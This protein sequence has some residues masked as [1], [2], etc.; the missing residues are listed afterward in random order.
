MRIIENIIPG[1][2]QD[3]IENVS[4]Q[5][6]EWGYLHDASGRG[7]QTNIPAFVHMFLENGQIKSPWYS[8]FESIFCMLSE[9]SGH[10]INLLHR[11]RFGLYLP[12]AGVPEH[13]NI[14]TDSAEP[15]TVLLYYVNDSDG[16]TYFFNHQNE[17]VDTV[18]AKKGR[19]V[20]FDGSIK[21]ASSCPKNGS[22]ITLNI[23][24]KKGLDF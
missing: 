5:R 2:L 20:I 18:S 7:Y 6:F 19:A 11:I 3:Y 21:H 24:F 14:H 1:S 22:R 16:P 12:L 8:N 9:V 17:V 23:N 4:F 10:S 15:H 13:N